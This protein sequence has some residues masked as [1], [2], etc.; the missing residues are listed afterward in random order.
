MRQQEED[1]FTGN[2]A[3]SGA[4][5]RD[6]SEKQLSLLQEMRMTYGWE[7]MML[8]SYSKKLGKEISRLHFFFSLAYSLTLSVWTLFFLKFLLCNLDNKGDF[9][10]FVYEDSDKQFKQ[11]GEP[12]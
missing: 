10:T 12:E 8:L 7:L 5:L 6:H 9:C 1:F 3:P 4:A 2:Q 11:N